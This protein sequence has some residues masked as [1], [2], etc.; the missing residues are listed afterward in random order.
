[1]KSWTKLATNIFGGRK[2]DGAVTARVSSTRGE[3]QSV[4][5]YNGLI[6][7]EKLRWIEDIAHDGFRYAIEYDG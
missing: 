3:E 5:I 4:I 1:M 7:P 6:D 2:D